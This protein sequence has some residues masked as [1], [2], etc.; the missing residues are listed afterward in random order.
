M[1]NVFNFRPQA[2][3]L[4]RNGV[5]PRLATDSLSFVPQKT[6]LS[7][8]DDDALI[9]MRYTG[10]RCGPPEVMARSSMRPRITIAVHRTSRHL[11]PNTDGSTESL[12]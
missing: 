2:T 11:R 3:T 10:I 5:E 9:F 1:L 6:V 8:T 12:R 7:K 4:K